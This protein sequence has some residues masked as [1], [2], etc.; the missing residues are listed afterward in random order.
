[1]KKVHGG[2]LIC[3]VLFLTAAIFTSVIDVVLGIEMA[4]AGTHKIKI[5]NICRFCGKTASS[6]KD[7]SLNSND[8]VSMLKTTT[9]LFIPLMFA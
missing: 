4:D 1:M 7:S 3:D 8:M 6:I 2:I 5:A 9:I